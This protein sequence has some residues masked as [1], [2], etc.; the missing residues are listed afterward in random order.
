MTSF[1]LKADGT[2]WGWGYN[3]Y[4]YQLGYT[5]GLDINLP[6]KINIS[7]VADIASG[8]EHVLAL[9]GDGSVWAWGL[10][11]AGHLGNG[12]GLISP[13]PV[14]SL[15]SQRPESYTMISGGQQHSFALKPGAG[16]TVRAWGANP[17]G[18]LGDGTFS[19]SHSPVLVKSLTD[20]KTIASDGGAFHTVA[21][22]SDGLVWAWG[23]NVYGQ[24]GDGTTVNSPSPKQV[25][26][27][28]GVSSVA[29]GYMHTLALINGGIRAW[30][31][32]EHGQLGSNS[33]ANSPLPVS[34][35]GLNDVKFI[36]G[37]SRHSLAVRSNGTV[38]AW[39][40]NE[41]GQLGDNSAVDK[42]IPVQVFGLEGVKVVSGGVWF[43]LALKADGT[44]WA[45]G[46]NAGGQLGDGTGIN[47][48]VPV[49][50]SGLDNVRIIAAGADH[51]LALKADGT[52]WAWGHNAYGQLGDGTLVTRFSPIQVSDLTNVVVIGCGVENSFAI[53]ADGTVWAWGYNNRG[54]LG[55]GTTVMRTHP[56][57]L[58]NDNCAVSATTGSNITVVPIDPATEQT[59]VT[60]TFTNVTGGGIV[61]VNSY[62]SSVLPANFRLSTLQSY[63][64]TTTAEYNGYI[65]ICIKYD[66]PPV[67]V[68]ESYLRLWHY[69]DVNLAA[70][71]LPGVDPYFDYSKSGWE[72]VTKAGSPDTTNHV[73]CGTV[74]CLSPFIIGMPIA[75]TGPTAPVPVSTQTTLSAPYNGETSAEWDFGDGTLEPGTISGDTWIGAHTYSTP[76]TYSIRLSL[77][78]AGGA[79]VGQA[80]YRIVIYDSSGGFVT[81]GGWIDSPAGALSA[82]PD[83]A[84]KANFSFEAK[85]QKKTT[86]PSGNLEFQFK[87]GGLTFKAK[88]IDWLVVAGAKAQFKG[89]GTINGAGSYR[90][91][92]TVI[93]GD[94]PG[95]GG[96][97]LFRIRIWDAAG[98]GLIYDNEV[99]KDENGDPATV[100]AA[101][102]IVIHK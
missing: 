26:G 16:G 34:V 72:N 4:N 9:K 11:W 10:N 100:I 23:L 57:Q 87:E 93:D 70:G 69:W 19:D 51:S 47:S 24:L 65:D 55:D 68:N 59:P 44:V 54:Q 14:Q 42:R 79:L 99:G 66:Q 101:G 27:L 63:S 22:K 18:Q 52:V 90:F 28:D 94:V 75:I 1:A 40:W 89:T 3:K 13:L 48:L 36:S 30:G 33:D 96:S 67:G 60:V 32:N 81:G 76:G 41:H 88:A 31:W 73:I 21:L 61:S 25:A 78:D 17:F 15:F 86:T 39:G 20:V 82:H 85:Y 38:W 64:V 91:L 56:V 12:S 71:K 2:V 83:L 49:Q 74:T 102:S 50:V 37:G 53:K 77:V 29:E 8:G 6:V 58:A 35:S 62:S 98:G 97:D 43:S 5:A 84:G 95:G 92:I 80:E 45:W 46:S 7:G